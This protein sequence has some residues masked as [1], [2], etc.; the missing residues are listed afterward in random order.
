MSP[1][2]DLIRDQSDTWRRRAILEGVVG[3]SLTVV[4]VLCAA[5]GETW[6]SM[7]A[8]MAAGATLSA[9]VFTYLRG[10]QWMRVAQRRES[11]PAQPWPSPIAEKGE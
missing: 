10:R 8:G 5:R 11:S 2:T 3:V 1:T 4:A 9:A 7:L 6:H